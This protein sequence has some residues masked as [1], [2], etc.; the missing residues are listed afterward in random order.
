MIAVLPVTIFKNALRIVL[1]VYLG[2]NVDI[3]FVTDSMLH[4]EGGKPFL[5]LAVLLMGAVL[6]ALR[7]YE[8]RSSMIEAAAAK[9]GAGIAAGTMEPDGKKMP[10]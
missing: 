3:G 2:A 8:K 1:L 7:K 5:I 6:Y 9:A 4:E 10:V